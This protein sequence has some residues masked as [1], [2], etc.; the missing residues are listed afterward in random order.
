MLQRPPQALIFITNGYNIM[1]YDIRNFQT[2]V[3]ERSRTI[4]VLADFWAD[5]CAPCKILGPVLEKLAVKY[6][7]VWDLKKI[8]TEIFR[9]E[10]A[11]Y[12]V[13]SIPNV[14]LF[15]DGKL[16]DEFVGALP[17]KSVEQWLRKALPD[18]FAGTL[19]RAKQLLDHFEYEQAQEL[20]TPVLAQAPDHADAKALSILSI[21]FTNR[22]EAMRLVEELPHDPAHWDRL[23]ACRALDATLRR[24]ETDDQLPEA[25]VREQYLSAI[26]ALAA[27]QFDAALSAFIDVLRSDRFY[28]NDNSRK[29]CI[30]MFKFFGEDHEITMKYRKAFDRAF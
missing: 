9:D 24:L 16:A 2:D 27:R 25:P 30:A 14:K 7:G 15:I 20:L 12:N 19:Q 3:I 5:W 28:D 26:K 6:T 13:Q 17:E 23:E 22:N 10:A 4:P 29:T 18:P 1:S 11:A 8:N 21:F